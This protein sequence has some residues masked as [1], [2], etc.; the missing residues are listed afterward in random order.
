MAVEIQK[1][2]GYIVTE[3]EMRYITL[4]LMGAMERKNKTSR[5]RIAVITPMGESMHAFVKKK[6]EYL[7]DIEINECVFCSLFDKTAIEKLAPDLVVSFSPFSWESQIPVYT[8]RGFLNDDDVENINKLLKEGEDRREDDFFRR[9]LFF[10]NQEFSSREEV[11]CY[12]CSKL[13]DEGLVPP[14]YVQD[15]FEREKVAP[16]CY[17]RMF[18]IPHPIRKSAYENCIAVCSLKS[19]IAWGSQ[20]VR[21]VFLFVLGKEHNK[22]FDLIFEQMMQ[23]LDQENKVKLLARECSYDRFISLFYD[24]KI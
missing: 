15:V 13:V 14:T 23:L 17:G 7:H 19:P 22:D 11:I 9:N 1:H 18:A 6:L 5:K 10:P 3:D 4:H 16:T 24:K 21:L 2:F 20:K 12:L 8:C